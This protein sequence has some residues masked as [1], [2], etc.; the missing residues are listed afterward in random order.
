MSNKKHRW[1]LEED[2]YCCETCVKYY[3]AEKSNMPVEVLVKELSE[4]F[5]NISTTSLRM[6]I[7]NIK[8]ILEEEGIENS[9]HIGP[10]SNYSQQNKK[11]MQNV[12]RKQ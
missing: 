8:Q 11:A 4:H 1:S 2:T 10:L 3:V 7:Q 6:K 5:P 9:L 12:L